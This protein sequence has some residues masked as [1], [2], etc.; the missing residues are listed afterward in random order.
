M[1]QRG[2]SDKGYDYKAWQLKAKEDRFGMY[3][4]T[5]NSVACC[6]AT[7][8]ELLLQDEQFGVYSRI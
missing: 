6:V 1:T 8:G 3:D 2:S 7:Q 4:K 5:H